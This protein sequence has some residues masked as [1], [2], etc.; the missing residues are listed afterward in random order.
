M[1]NATR[2]TA[3]WITV[4]EGGRSRLVMTWS[5]PAAVPVTTTPAAPVPVAAPVPSAA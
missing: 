1:D 5:V 4:R 2:P 3:R